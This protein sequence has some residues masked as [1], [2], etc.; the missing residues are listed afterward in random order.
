MQQMIQP[1]FCKPSEND[2]TFQYEWKAN[3]SWIAWRS[4]NV[5]QDAPLIHQWVNREYAKAFWNMTGSLGLFQS[6]Y[7]CI[8]QNPYAHSFIACRKG[9][10]TAQ[11]D[12]YKVVADELADHVDAGQDDCGFHL[13]M[14]PIE[15]NNLPARGLTVAIIQSFLD[16]YF[17]FAQA[18]VMWAE[19]DS[20]NAKSIRLLKALGFEYVKKIQM[21]YKEALVYRR[22]R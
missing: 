16:W 17:S 19:P 8:M 5:L 11:L 18:K 22:G 12:I 7:Q 13:I 3:G 14:A 10:P 1:L 2:F 4:M 6:C 20:R 21:S 9:Q 15:R